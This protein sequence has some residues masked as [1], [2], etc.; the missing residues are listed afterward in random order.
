MFGAKSFCAQ[1]ELEDLRR[2]K[3]ELQDGQARLQQALEDQAATT[4][5]QIRSMAAM[6][7]EAGAHLRDEHEVAMTQLI[8]E[9]QDVCEAADKALLKS[10]ASP[11]HT[12]M[13][14]LKT[15]L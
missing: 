3:A 7:E 11:F 4:E 9:H 8:A 13:P 6:S 15:L 2:E 5:Q 1:V 12:F 10:E 14:F